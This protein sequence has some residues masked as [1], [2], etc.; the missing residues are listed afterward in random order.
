MAYAY[1]ASAF[2]GLARFAVGS[3]SEPRR[4]LPRR[5]RR[6]PARAPRPAAAPARARGSRPR[7]AVIVTVVPT[8][9]RSSSTAIVAAVQLDV[10]LGDRQARGRCPWPS[11]R[12]RARR[13]APSA[14]ASMPTP[15]SRTRRR[16][17]SPSRDSRADGERAAAG[18][19]VQRVLDRRSSSARAEQ[20]AVD[21]RAS[22]GRRRRRAS[23]RHPP[24]RAPVRYGVDDLLEHHVGEV[25]ATRLRLGRRGEARE[26]R[27][28]LPEQPHLRED[29]GHALVEHRRR[30]ARP[31]STC[32]RRRCSAFSWI[33]VSGFLMSCATWRAM[34]AQASRRLVRSSSPRWRCR[35][36][37][38]LLN[39]STSRRSS[40]RRGRQHAR[41]EV[42]ARDPPRRA[43]EAVHRVGDALGHL[44]ADAGAEQDE[45]QRREQHAAIE[46]VD[47]R[48]RSP[49]AA[50]RA[51]PSGSR[52][53]SPHAHRRRGHQVRRRRR[54]DSRADVASAARR[55]AM[56]R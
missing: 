53:A 17:T 5:G 22:A 40:S 51:A 25:V 34:S 21:A 41:V 44:V 43:R 33:G 39:A 11:W 28:D 36:S 29:V 7:A 1:L 13:S 37:A 4:R 31:R 9:A 42:A 55:A 15:V 52:R 54:R 10:A 46:L 14:S 20:H 48:A 24:R 56:A 38:M 2:I 18:H 23:M 45:E 49:A 26:L 12:S 16:T 6:R 19:R 8:P 50:G 32:T 3:R 30:A 35:S 27:R 47:L